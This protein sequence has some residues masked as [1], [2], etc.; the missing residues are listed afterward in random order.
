M[1]E[2]RSGTKID[3]YE[4]THLGNIGQHVEL[5]HGQS[6]NKMLNHTINRGSNELVVAQDT[7]VDV[8]AFEG[9][10][11]FNH[12][13]LFDS[14]LWQKGL[15][16][17]NT[18]INSPTK[19]TVSDGGTITTT[20]VYQVL[21]PLKP[22]TVYTLS[23][24]IATAGLFVDAYTGASFDTTEVYN[25]KPSITFTTPS[26]LSVPVAIRILGNNGVSGVVEKISLVEGTVLQE[27]VADV[28]GVTNPAIEIK[29][30][31]L[32]K[33]FTPTY[34]LPTSVKAEIISPY[35][36]KLGGNG[37]GDYAAIAFNVS[38]N[39]NY[40]LSALKTNMYVAIYKMDANTAI[41]TYRE[42]DF[43]FNSGDNTRLLFVFKAVDLT[44]EATLENIML[45]IGTTAKPFEPYRSDSLT[46]METF[47]TGD[48]VYMENGQARVIR[49]TKEILLDEN[50][51]WV[52]SDSNTGRKRIRVPFKGHVTSSEKVIKY[53]GMLLLSGD[54]G[55]NADCSALTATDLWMTIPNTDS[56]WGQ[57][58][59]PTPEEIKA[60][61][62]GWIMYHGESHSAGS[63]VPY[64]GTGLKYWAVRFTP[65]TNG[66]SSAGLLQ[67]TGTPVLPRTRSDRLITTSWQP[68]RMLYSTAAAINMPVKTIGSLK[69][70]KGSNVIELTEGKIVRERV[71]PYWDGAWNINNGST[72]Y[73]TSWTKFKVDYFLDIYKDGKF[74]KGW[75]IYNNNTITPVGDLAQTNDFNANSFYEADYVPLEP[76]RVSI[77]TN[78]VTLS[79]SK[80]FYSAVNQST[81]DI[82]NL[83]DRVSSNQSLLNGMSDS[84]RKGKNLTYGNINGV[85][86][87]TVGETKSFKEINDQ[88]YQNKLDLAWNIRD[89]GV[90]SA[91]AED[92]LYTLATKIGQ[93]GTGNR[94]YKTIYNGSGYSAGAPNMDTSTFVPATVKI[95]PNGKHVVVIKSGYYTPSGTGGLF[96]FAKNGTFGFTKIQEFSNL[97]SLYWA[98]W[99]SET[100]LLYSVNGMVY[101][102]PFD[103]T[104]GVLNEGARIYLM[105][106][107]GHISTITSS[108]NGQWIGVLSKV[109]N[110]VYFAYRAANGNWT[111]HSALAGVANNP[112]TDIKFSPN[113]KDC[114]VT[115]GNGGI[116]HYKVSSDTAI[117]YYT[118]Y[119][120]PAKPAGEIQSLSR[121]SFDPRNTGYLVMMLGS[122][123][124][125]FHHNGVSSLTHYGNYA[126]HTTNSY[127]NVEEG[128]AWQPGG[129]LILC[130]HRG[131]AEGKRLTQFN[132]SPNTLTRDNDLSF[133]GGYVPYVD[134]APSGNWMAYGAKS[135]GTYAFKMNG[136][137]GDHIGYEA[138]GY[139]ALVARPTTAI[140]PTG[141]TRIEINGQFYVLQRR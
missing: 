32:L 136:P 113:S 83:K 20:N 9:K 90:S 95:N 117:A 89:K 108:P 130:G 57:N 135:G 105:T 67:G 63:L 115:L 73:Q 101:V 58:Y 76:Y 139:E 132:F 25:T 77:S 110:V 14:G 46:L 138:D 22:N 15:G 80:D 61:F 107:D 106:T 41:V 103:P 17:F 93:I 91:Y 127:S 42:S 13:P 92:S 50:I 36:I 123:V 71:F 8:I 39:T 137:R 140:L 51:D 96:I 10:T 5:M 86:N 85:E 111:N 12:V 131:D 6:T 3:A 45:N 102:A 11:V 119:G 53:N 54:T 49:N 27:F 109:S 33:S 47:H 4:A 31:N 114:F 125:L 56:G 100:E 81:E 128:I 75:N 2:L 78:P 28:R 104:T 52:F 112:P 37:S 87:S 94:L 122:Y 64:N 1:A 19:I 70:K 16:D 43:V 118:Q 23:A 24:V 40:F 126:L 84:I 72:G 79:Y 29:S 26:T 55:L 74:D 99:V 129:T 60:Y 97:G 38:K 133:P 116:R 44:K 124:S 48:K 120:V 69:L 21:V 18:I 30:N 68:Y 66:V 121:I 34:R 98:D 82:A 35:K 7:S 65:M 62:M 141:D 88:F 134:W 59:T